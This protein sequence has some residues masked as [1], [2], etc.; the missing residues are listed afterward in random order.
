MSCVLRVLNE[1]SGNR[2]I[3]PYKALT[4]Q[5]GEYFVFVAKDSVASQQKVQI[6]PRLGDRIVIMDGIREGDKI[7]TEGFQRLRDG[8]KIQVG[9]PAAPQGAAAKK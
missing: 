3:I 1:Q 4:E 9:I 6:G 5:M 2:L 8:G 7:V